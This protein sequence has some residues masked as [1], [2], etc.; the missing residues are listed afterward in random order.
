M[1]FL[2]VEDQAALRRLYRGVL[3]SMGHADVSE[4]VNGREGL[5]RIRAARFDVVVLDQ[6]MPEMTGL[7][8][9]CALERERVRP[10]I[11]FVSGSLP[12]EARAP[13][14]VEGVLPKPFTHDEFAAA[15][16]AIVDR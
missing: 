6:E 8:L 4:V 11:L 15:I 2:L 3:L 7:E 1:R 12:A 5:D 16:R 14:R 9:L 10:A 13:G